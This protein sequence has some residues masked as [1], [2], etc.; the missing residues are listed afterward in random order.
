M[1]LVSPQSS[2]ALC[3]RL[4]LF[5]LVVCSMASL[6]ARA[7]TVTGSG[8]TGMIPKFTA[9]SKIGNS[10]ITENAGK[11]GINI[12][13]PQ[14]ELHVKGV[15][16]LDRDTDTASLLMHRTGKKTF[17]FG[18]NASGTNNGEFFIADLGSAV[19]GAGD[20]RLTISNNGNI[21]INTDSPAYKLSVAGTIYSTVGF[22]F[23]DGTVQTTAASGLGTFIRFT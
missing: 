21:G 14:R 20:R 5:L 19:T 7:Q 9:S 11:I 16:R 1:H 22:R 4:S 17:I 8:T 23:P 15:L 2:E 6:T 18:V 13:V 10:I 12:P 3:A